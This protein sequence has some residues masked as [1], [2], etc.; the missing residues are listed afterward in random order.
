M[1]SIFVSVCVQGEDLILHDY[2]GF[3]LRTMCQH[4]FELW[5]EFVARDDEA[6][7]GFVE[8]VHD[9]L[10]PKVGVKSADNDTLTEA[11]RQNSK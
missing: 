3:N 7:L 6:D 2:N 8:A 10:V 9:G 1:N 11:R 4:F 5:Q